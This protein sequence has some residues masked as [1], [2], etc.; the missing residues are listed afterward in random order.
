MN[1]TT[2][3]T[4]NA[5][6][7]VDGKIALKVLETKM[8]GVVKKIAKSVKIDGFRKGKVPA[9]VIKTRYKEQVE[10]DAQQAAIQDILES[11]LKEL[12]IAPNALI[13][14]PIISKFDKGESDIELEIKLSIMPTFELDKVEEYV[15]EVKLKVITKAQIDE[16]LEEIAKNRAPLSEI[17]EDRAL[18][19]MIQQILILKDL[20]ME[21]HLMAARERTSILLLVLINLFRDLRT[22]L[23]V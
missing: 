13:G 7:I 15:P 16:R 21:K 10:Q 2:K 3:R 22:R 9:K 18:Q 23:L 14:N 6:A 1:F 5:N 20:L 11:A 12:G 4:N 19:K 8:E 17:V